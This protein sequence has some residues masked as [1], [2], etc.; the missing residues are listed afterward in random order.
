MLWGRPGGEEEGHLR[1]VLRA[2]VIVEHAGRYP[3]R[4]DIFALCLVVSPLLLL[5]L[6]SDEGCQ[7]TAV[8]VVVVIR[9]FFGTT[10]ESSPENPHRPAKIQRMGRRLACDRAGCG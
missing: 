7:I 1:L 8:S 6:L 2:E 10:S 3:V 9:D 4:D 5:V